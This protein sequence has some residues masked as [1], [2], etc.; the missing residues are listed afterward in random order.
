L[1][2]VQVSEFLH[3]RGSFA[4]RKGD[5]Y[6]ADVNL[7]FLTRIFSEASELAVDNYEPGSASIPLELE[8][9]TFGGSN[10]T[11]FV[12]IGG[13][14]RYG[15]DADNDGLPDNI[16][17]KAVGLA[18]DDVV[19]GLAIMTPTLAGLIPGAEKVT[20]KFLS[21]KAS[22]G[23]AGLVGIDEDF[24]AV[25]ANDVEVN[26]NTFYLPTDPTG[27]YLNAALQLLGPPSINY[28]TSFADS[29]EDANGNGLLDSYD[30]DKNDNG[31]LDP[32]EDLNGDG[33][34]NITEDLD[35]DGLVG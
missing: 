5:T 31:L 27:G 35:G 10:L 8:A 30:E 24:L 14:Y 19:F 20:P 6:T 7:G 11:G 2:E 34:L 17:E 32:G 18:I 22:V 3:V 23:Y 33:P 16:N 1:A 25:N 13:P 29:P 4:F 15:D 21:V 12:G 28:R 26:I 9:M